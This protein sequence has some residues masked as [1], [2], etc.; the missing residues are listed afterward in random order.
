L[1]D[2]VVSLK[3]ILVERE[4]AD[5]PKLIKTLWGS[6]LRY[7]TTMH[8]IQKMLFDLTIKENM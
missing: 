6:T 5:R 3:E 7:S 2:L 4:G 1:I 8:F